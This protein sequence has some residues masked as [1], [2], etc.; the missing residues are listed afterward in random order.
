VSRG[1]RRGMSSWARQV[2][3]ANI[4]IR[5]LSDVTGRWESARLGGDRKSIDRS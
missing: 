4:D 5:F 3:A 2:P 1:S